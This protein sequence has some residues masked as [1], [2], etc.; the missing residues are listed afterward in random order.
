MKKLLVTLLVAATTLNFAACGSKGEENKGGTTTDKKDLA[1]SI[2]VQVEESWLP[3]YEQVKAEVLKEYPKA[4]IEFKTTGSFD[5]LDVIDSTD[6][7][8]SDVAD[9]FALP[10]DRL[11]GLAKNNVLAAIDAEAMAAEVGGF[12]DFKNGMGGNFNVDGDYLAFP[13]NIET[14]IGFGNKENAAAAGIDT[15]KDIE[16]TSL[17]YNQILTTVHDAWFGVAF[18]NAEGFEFLSKDLKSDGTKAWADLSDDQ[19]KLFEGLFNYWKAHKD[20]NTSLWDKDAA[21]GY[22]DEQFKTG[23]TDAI[24][25]DGPWATS[26][27]SELVGSAENLEVIPLNQITFN[28][29]SL[30][31]WKGGWGLGVNAR[32]EENADKMELAQAFIMEIVNPENAKELFDAT[33]KILEN[34]TL[35]SYKGIDELQYKVVE[36][37]MAAYEEAVNRPLFSEY[38]QVWATWQNSLLSWSAKNPANAEAAYNEVKASFDAMMTTLNQ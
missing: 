18:A 14:L 2:S 36:A 23:G 32:C 38:G 31:H 1:V 24:K 3:Y 4:T 5:H 30:Q 19:K 16:F 29:K 10:A 26:S 17:E 8:N 21:G 37:T 25:I 11:Y 9:V 33:G 12:A 22:I 6:P 34:A 35:E 28:G 27:V 13:Y 15:T 7:T 20:N